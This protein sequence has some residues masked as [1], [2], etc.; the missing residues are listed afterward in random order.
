M[1]KNKRLKNKLI[2][3]LIFV[4]LVVGAF[5]VPG[6]KSRS[7]S[8][9]S[10]DAIVYG[11]Q[12]YIGSTN[13]GA[14]I[15]LF[16]L[17]GERLTRLTTIESE[18]R[19]TGANSFS[20]L[21]FSQEGGRLYLFAVDGRYLYQY[22]ITDPGQIVL[23]NKIK[24]NA[25]DWFNGVT[26]VNGRIVT[27]G[28]NG[29]KFY[30]KLLQNISDYKIY[31]RLTNNVGFSDSGELIFNLDNSKLATF[32]TKV[33]AII[34]EAQLEVRENHDR[35]PYVD[36][37][38]A[39]YVVDDS[40]F[41]KFDY[42][43]NL[44]GS[45]KHTSTLGYDVAGLPGRDYLFF[46][47][48]IGLVKIDKRTMEPLDWVFTQNLG[49][50]SGWAIGLRVVQDN[51]GEKIVLFNN[52]SLVVLDENL[53]LIDFFKSNTPE[54]RP[55]E[56]LSLTADKIRAPGNAEVSLRG[57][58]FGLSEELEVSFAKTKTSLFADDNGRFTAILTVPQVLPTRTDIKVTG[59][60]TGLTY[61]LAFQIE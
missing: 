48:G 18:S 9:F 42:N 52:S 44:Q 59:K 46:S 21:H 24:D 12:L 29:I 53:D 61:S 32:D 34:A 45:F 8:Y 14:G 28:T 60:T 2:I 5:L 13:M 26:K 22:D 3:G 31:N 20:N 40:A 36:A 38:G 33:G 55:I 7:K 56:A 57:T 16:R 27:I 17:E 15:E 25:F 37:D 30:N 4:F 51:G 35:K 23:V 41:K 6:A 58:G 43:G 50:P 39:L 49:E 11:G 47:D 1:Q 10:G 19:L 54:L